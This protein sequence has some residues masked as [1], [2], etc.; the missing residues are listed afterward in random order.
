MVTQ[1]GTYVPPWVDL[2]RIQKAVERS[3]VSWSPSGRCAIEEALTEILGELNGHTGT[4][5]RRRFRSLVRNRIAK[6]RRRDQI[7]RD[8]ASSRAAECCLDPMQESACRELIEL[9]RSATSPQEFSL[10]Y[11][12]A[13]GTSY[14][15]L[16]S[17]RST[18]VGTLKSQVSRL[19]TRL[20]ASLS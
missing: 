11:E 10:L 2:G 20:R 6:Y 8:L 5:L 18:S 17:I 15:A 14:E 9:V 12:F 7:E 1:A 13:S 4:T 3:S 16:A 19:R